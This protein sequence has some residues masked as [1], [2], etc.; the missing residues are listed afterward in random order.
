MLCTW[1]PGSLS[2][3]WSFKLNTVQTS[4]GTQGV[5]R[6]T[7]GPEPGPACWPAGR[8][9]QGRLDTAPPPRWGVGSGVRQAPRVLILNLRLAAKGPWAGGS[10][11]LCL[12]FLTIKEGQ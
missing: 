2:L 11:V 9:L 3:C 8:A 12:G 1:L 7:P 4:R 6:E 10:T 5:Q